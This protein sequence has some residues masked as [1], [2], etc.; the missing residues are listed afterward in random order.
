MKSLLLVW[1]ILGGLLLIQ[2]PRAHYRYDGQT[3]LPDTMYTPG[4][5]ATRDTSIICNRSTQDVRNVPES[6]KKYIYRLYGVTSHTAGQYEVD[7]LFSLEFG[8]SNDTTN[9]WIQPALPK[10][11]FHEKDVL[12]NWLHKEVC[13]GKMTVDS[14][15]HLV[16]PDWLVG[17]RQM[18]K[19][20]QNGH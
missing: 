4:Q 13:S 5:I 9:L 15:T 1:I 3:P 8:G 16:M 20:K 2:Q 18:L 12:E 19:E 7:H 14:A 10:P 11:G 6:L 17:Y